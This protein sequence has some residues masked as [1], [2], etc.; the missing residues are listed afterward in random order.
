MSSKSISVLT[1]AKLREEGVGL[2]AG[3]GNTL[4]NKR[5]LHRIFDANALSIRPEIQGEYP[6]ITGG[7][8]PYYRG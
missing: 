5:V 4:K 7:R 8:S 2:S 3:T 6:V 1:K